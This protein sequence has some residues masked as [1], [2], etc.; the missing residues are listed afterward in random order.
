[1]NTINKIVISLFFFITMTFSN[2]L[3]SINVQLNWKHQFEHAGFYAAIEKGFYKDVGLKVNLFEKKKGSSSFD[4]IMNSNVDFAVGYSSLVLEYASGKPV[5]ALASLFQHSPLVFLSK[6]SSNIR[7]ISD[8]IGRK[9]MINPKSKSSASL[10]MMIK[11]EG[12]SYDDMILLNHSYNTNDLIDG[13]TEVMASY[14]SNQPYALMKKNI[15]F[16]ILDPANYGYDFYE[17]ILFTHKKTIKNN[18]MLVNKFLTATLKGW[19][20]ALKNENEII[21]VILDKYS[22]RKSKEALEYEANIIKNSLMPKNIPVGNI[23]K[24]RFERIISLYEELGLSVYSNVNIDNFIYKSGKEISLSLAQKEWIREHPQV[25]F[26]GD[27]NWLPYE[28]FVDGEYI[29]VVNEH[30]KLLEQYTG[31]TFVKIPTIN[32]SQSIELSEKKY[33]DVLSETTSSLLKDSLSFTK[34]YLSSPIVM[35]MKKSEKYKNSITDIL[36][37]KI[38]VIKD[39]GYISEIQNVYPKLNY[40]EVTNIQD[41]LL[42]IENGEADVLLCALPQASYWINKYSLQNVRIVGKTRFL[43]SLAFGVRSDYQVL[44]DILNKAIDK[45]PQTQQQEILTN[46]TKVKYNQKTDYTTLWIVLTI[47]SSIICLLVFRHKALSK[48]NKELTYLSEIDHLTKIYNRGKLNSLLE[49][50]L[51]IFNRYDT[52]FG[53]IIIDIDYFKEVNDIYG[54]NVGDSVLVEFSKIL[55][56]NIRDVDYIGRWGGEE[57]LV[58]CPR[59]N[60][61]GI[62]KVAGKLHSVIRTHKFKKVGQKTASFGAAICK[63]KISKKEL[64]KN[65]DKALYY[66]KENG[67]DGV[68][69]N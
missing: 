2:E 15:K 13:T 59:I 55:K 49:E 17:N 37:K 7:T 28:A 4:E 36:N 61:E 62:I 60:E 51:H 11:N 41:G 6:Q 63:N 14:I 31:L 46:W 50:Q 53:L 26:T 3:K 67:R 38:A 30:L 56:D 58:I 48:H 20:Y 69:F 57:F 42:S 8:M 39:Y 40:H 35:V 44:V 21:K 66:V 19:S 65:A 54:H 18:P 12:I 1:M 34:S 29:G 64:I 33:V 32:W 47:T 45:I 27:P 24:K 68:K 43:A 52:F 22:N 16:N 10:S 5:V 23:D 25:Y 9:V